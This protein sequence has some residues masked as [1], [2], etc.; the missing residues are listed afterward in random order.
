TLGRCRQLGVHE[1]EARAINP[2][3]FELAETAEAFDH[4][5]GTEVP[6]DGRGAERLSAHARL[7]RQLEDALFW[8]HVQAGARDRHRQL[9]FGN[10]AQIAVADAQL[11]LDQVLCQVVENVEGELDVAHVARLHV[12]DVEA[13]VS[14]QNAVAGEIAQVGLRFERGPFAHVLDGQVHGRALAASELAVTVARSI[15]ADLVAVG[16]HRLRQALNRRA[17]FRV[18][19]GLAALREEPDLHDLLA[20]DGVLRDLAHALCVL[21]QRRGGTRR[22][23]F[24][25]TPT[26]RDLGRLGLTG[27][28]LAEQQ[29]FLVEVRRVALGHGAH[30]VR[31]R[32]A[33][34]GERNPDRE[35]LTGVHRIASA[36]GR[37]LD[38]EV[39]HRRATAVVRWGLGPVDAEPLQIAADGGD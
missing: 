16:K 15:V 24:D 37:Y 1:A 28:H 36:I 10:D 19:G 20:S 12:R 34:V 39:F 4:G 35:R 6:D 29:L 18:G 22:A 23:P 33:L 30:L 14:E 7:R 13:A 21:W 17:D 32:L 31:R 3:L 38:L 9:L 26:Q 8:V 25:V 11:H 2:Y 27:T 5:T